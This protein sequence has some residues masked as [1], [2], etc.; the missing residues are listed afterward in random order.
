MQDKISGGGKIA[1]KH[2]LIAIIVA[3]FVL[4]MN[5]LAIVGPPPSSVLG[6][7][8]DNQQ[9][10]WSTGGDAYWNRVTS[11]YYYGGDSAESGDI[12]SN[13]ETW[14]KTT[15]TG[16]GTLKFY[17]RVSS[18]VNVGY[19]RFYIDGAKVA[20]ITG[21][22]N[23]H[24]KTFSIGSGS[25][26][27]VWKYV[28]TSSS[29]GG[30]GPVDP[31]AADS[32]G[33]QE[34]STTANDSN[35]APLGSGGGSLILDRGWLDKVEWIPATND[36]PSTPSKPSGE[37]NGCTGVTYTYSTS[38]TDPNGDS[39]KYGW[40]WNGDGVV[41]YW[42]GYYTSGS[43]CYASH[44]WNSAGTYYVRVKAMDSRG[45]ESGWSQALVV[46]ITANSPPDANFWYSPSEPTT[47]DVIQFHDSSSDPDGDSLTYHW[48]FGDGTTSSE[49]NPTHQYAEP[50]TYTV[51]LTVTDEYGASDSI[52]KS[53]SVSKPTEII[54]VAILKE[55]SPPYYA[56]NQTKHIL[57]EKGTWETQN[58]TYKFS[59]D[60]LS[61]PA[62][63]ARLNND[64]YRAFIIPGIG[65]GY[66][67]GFLENLSLFKL[68]VQQFVSN[69]GGYFG[70][71]GGAVMAS[72]GI[73][74]PDT[75]MEHLM[76]RA[77]LGLIPSRVKQDFA[78]RLLP[79]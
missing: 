11:I 49:R 26:Q 10:T 39:I 45:A 74:D 12:G 29:G 41:D 28:K 58:K 44:T 36:P 24:Q 52:T 7:A 35:T 59:C 68:K 19:L 71:C 46:T 65:A 1:E 62:V 54:K 72:Q 51:T 18:E 17:W 43:T 31:L 30:G 64:N 15:V 23:W 33:S 34:I 25:H 53:I 69:G 14:I 4:P 3:S 79:A 75:P 13:E 5:G 60:I 27:L 76:N 42:T 16:P 56:S 21:N 61:Y 32:G 48:D 38:A 40:D 50:R 6:E 20:E 77:A 63:I 8:V 22:I 73:I 78:N 67:A 66:T 47:E 37:T 2:L 57:E 55:L 70:I 9:L